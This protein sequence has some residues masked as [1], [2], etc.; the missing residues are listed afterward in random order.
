VPFTISTRAN[1]RIVSV[2]PGAYLLPGKYQL[3][4]DPSVIVDHSGNVGADPV[5]LD[6]TIRPASNIKATSGIPAIRQAPSANPGQAIGITVPFD[7][8]T[9][10]ATFHVIDSNGNQSTR[11][12][13]M[14]S[15]DTT[16]GIAFF[17]VPVDAITGEVLVYSQVGNTRTDFTDGNF[18][19]QIVPVVSSIDVTSVSSDGLSAQI[20]LRGLG[21][22]EGNG[23]T[24][25]FG[26]TEVVDGSSG[27]G[28]DV[29][30]YYYDPALG[31]YIFNSNSAV[32]LT[33]PLEAGAFGPISVTTAGGVST[34]LSLGLSGITGVALSGTPA[35]VAVASANPGQA[36]TLTGSGL[37]TASDV[38]L[39]YVDGSGATRMVN[40]NPIAAASDGTSATLVIPTYAN[41]VFALQM[42]GASGQPLLQVV[43]VLDSYNVSGGTLQLFGRGLME[44]N[45]TR[46]QFAGDTLTDTAADSGPDVFYGRAFDNDTVNIDE[47]VHGLGTVTIA[48][49]GG[50]SAPLKL[51]EL[52]PGLGGLGDVAL[53]PATGQLWVIDVNSPANL[54]RIDM[55]TGQVLQTITLP[56][57]SFGSTY[58]GYAGLQVAPSAMTLGGMSVPAGSL[59]LFSGYNNPDQV[60]AIDPATGA[61]IATLA[62]LQNYDLT[63]GAY[64]PISK[65]LFVVNRLT[66]PNSIVEIDPANGA[67]L[68]NF[69]LPFYAG[70]AGLAI[71]PVTGNLWYGSGQSTNVV[72]LTRTGTVLRQVDLAP[73]GVNQNVIDGLAFDA[74]GNLYVAS[75][76][77]VV[78]KVNLA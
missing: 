43:P 12:V 45:N 19:I 47:P 77:G 11:N 48:T 8:S 74:A 40:L 4:L 66:G 44:G 65:H 75:N 68:S 54:N 72:E 64:D 7:P 62:L 69:A 37:S 23:S 5:T 26:T 63:A 31:Q 71:N 52:N 42:L 6:F 16:K 60:T 3:R 73:Q 30:D 20:V 59:L 57:D 39:R 50:T 61:A 70:Q 32:Y 21:L 46:Y 27:Q 34:S 15:V 28:P 17:Q 38:L 33:V 78:Y 14:T 56:V 53:D 24:Y 35:D 76:Q 67:E 9:A 25:R 29:N 55:T 18:L 13:R 36:V 51:N 41:G 58:G 10:F 49:A 22:I 2:L 1:G